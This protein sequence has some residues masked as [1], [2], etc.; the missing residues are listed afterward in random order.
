MNDELNDQDL[1]NIMAISNAHLEEIS[2]EQQLQSLTEV[3]SERIFH[4]QGGFKKI[5][6]ALDNT[7]KRIV[8]LATPLDSTDQQSRESFLREG[9]I[10][11]ALQHPNIV[12]LYAIGFID[13]NV[14]CF[15]MKLIQGE[16]FR[17]FMKVNDKAA[18]LDTFLKVS[19]AVAYAHN[20]GII[21]RDI[22][23]DNIQISSFG[24]VL[25]CD[26]GLSQV[27]LS[28]CD[29]STL[30]E[31]ASDKFAVQNVT[32]KGTIKG[33]PG[34]IAPEQVSKGLSNRASDIYALGALLFNILYGRI[35]C[36][37]KN[38][39]DTIKNTLSGKL[40]IPPGCISEGLHAVCLKALAFDPD[41]RYSTVD[42]LSAELRKYLSGFATQAENAGPLR[43]VKLL[44]RRHKTTSSLCCTFL[45]IAILFTLHYVNTLSQKE[46]QASKL[47]QK[48]KQER[49]EKLKLGEEALPMIM[50][51]AKK[52]FLAN[53]LNECR[54]YIETILKLDESFSAAINMKAR[55]FFLNGDYFA[56]STL[57]SAPENNS[58]EILLEFC[59]SA[60]VAKDKN[61]L[62]DQL[63]AGNY[64][65]SIIYLMH[66]LKFTDQRP[67]L[68]NTLSRWRR[69]HD[70]RHLISLAESL[71]EAEKQYILKRLVFLLKNYPVSDSSVIALRAA[72]ISSAEMK[73]EF[74]L[75]SPANIALHAAASTTGNSRFSPQNAVDGIYTNRWEAEP[76]PATILL[77]LGSLKRFNKLLLYFYHGEE[78]YYQYRIYL[79]DNGISFKLLTDRSHSSEIIRSHP[80]T[81][82][83]DEQ[84]AR[85][86]KI[87]IIKNSNN[88]A[89]HL[90]EFELYLEKDNKALGQFCTSSQ[91][92]VGNLTDGIKSRGNSWV[93]SKDELLVDLGSTQKVSRLLL[94]SDQQR[95]SYILM[96]SVNG[97]NYQLLKNGRGSLCE[98]TEQRLRYLKLL[99]IQN[100]SGSKFR[101]S[102]LEVY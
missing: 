63:Y 59:R 23:P 66:L 89:V 65:E 73:L 1:L 97:K 52:A 45:L 12:P 101:I 48:L 82:R 2:V 17:E 77:D 43:Q 32:L 40:N 76:S 46:K 67:K 51:K 71:P 21:H 99:K 85:Y 58:D 15:S 78:R 100:D 44:F 29:E 91:K 93:T 83:L 95:F 64:S 18:C 31:L 22:K 6:M 53:K 86:I 87:E 54:A 39:H 61:K 47:V 84:Q 36:R 88:P 56:A 33:T 26:W 8:A 35:P 75:L 9:R 19:D 98:F 34:Y 4:A 62:I 5:E 50:Q 60:R 13:E 74:F 7:T 94:S 49:S 25:L 27:D 41:H 80:Q 57:M 10:L 90:R 70:V 69:S 79:S 72:A 55:L 38:N 92:H 16:S 102:E 24:E 3:Y 42:Q 14:P 30:N 11:A 20:K 28:I 37:G 81:I 96:G 68:I